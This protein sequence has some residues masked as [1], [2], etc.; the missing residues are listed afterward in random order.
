MAILEELRRRGHEVALRTLSGEVAKLRSMEFEAK[1][2][3]SGIEALKMD[4]WKARTPIGG[5]KGATAIFGARAELD[6]PDLRRAIEE[7]RPDAVLVDI[8]SWGAL[9]A[10]EAWG[11]PWAS[12]SPL[13]LSL[14]SPDA[15]PFG[16]GLKPAR[17]PLGRLRDRL[18]WGS[19]TAVFDPRIRSRLNPLRTRLGIPPLN[20]IYEMFLKPPLLLYMTAEGFEYPR[21]DWPENI[22]MV[23]PCV[24][25]PPGELPPELAGIEDPFV[26]V[27]T[28]SEFQ[29]DGRLVRTALAGLAGE[30]YHVVATLPSASTENLSVPPNA[31]VLPFAPHGPIL[32]RAACAITHGGMGAT[33]KALARGIPVCVAPFGRDQFEVARRVEV[34][35]AGSRLPPWRLRPNRLRAKVREAIA[36]RAGAERVAAAFA[37]TGGP[38]AAADAFESRLGLRPN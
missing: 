1:P 4:D 33:Q 14:P 32:D 13:P 16:P 8:M 35:T 20:Q 17:G 6:A 11:G 9:A 36:S 3:A 12:F 18:I 28:S 37:A 23:G 2:I 7:E 10:A 15:P 29:D 5:V 24:W 27:T 30:P 34:A 38:P 22:V 21:S 31:T 25:N 19:Y 26:L